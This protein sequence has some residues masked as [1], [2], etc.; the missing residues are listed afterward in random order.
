[1]AST[2]RILGSMS[3]MPG[4]SYRRL[5]KWLHD[6]QTSQ[7]VVAMF[8]ISMRCNLRRMDAGCIG[9]MATRAKLITSIAIAHRD[10][11][12]QTRSFGLL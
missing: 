7:W 10:Q 2:T 6:Q 8:T 1:M 9:E 4:S 3:V 12:H 11:R 5:E